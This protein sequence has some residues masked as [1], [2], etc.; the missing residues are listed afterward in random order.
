M[1]EVDARIV[2]SK[3][4]LRR[5]DDEDL[6]REFKKDIKTDLVTSK[7][8]ARKIRLLKTSRDSASS[9]FA[10]LE[11]LV[12]LFQNVAKLIQK[13]D[14]MTD[15]NFILRKLFS[16]F[17]IKKGKVTQITQNSPFRELCASKNDEDCGLVTSRRIELRFPG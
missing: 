4:Q 15:L 1:A 17:V 5:E 7:E 12:E 3:E 11:E 14:N 2:E 10:S 9:T 16:N 8:L 6:R 13:I